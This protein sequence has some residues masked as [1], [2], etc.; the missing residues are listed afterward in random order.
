MSA[1]PQRSTRDDDEWLLGIVRLRRHHGS[2]RIAQHL[3]LSSARVRTLC[4]RV[5][6]DDLKHSGEDEA[7]VRS[8]YWRD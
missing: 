6:A 5:L 4:N 2:G 3:G 7:V 8:A 1:Q